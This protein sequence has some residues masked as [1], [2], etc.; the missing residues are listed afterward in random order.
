MPR[1]R[2]GE[3]TPLQWALVKGFNTKEST[4]DLGV[5]L[6][7]VELQGLRGGRYLA[8]A[9]PATELGKSQRLI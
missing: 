6:S 4:I 9:V 1:P 3:I 7:S 2:L 8:V 5:W